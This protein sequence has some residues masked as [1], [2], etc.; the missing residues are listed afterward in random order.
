[1]QGHIPAKFSKWMIAVVSL[2][3]L[4]AAANAE[5]TVIQTS[6]LGRVESKRIAVGS[7]IFVKVVSDWKEGRCR[8]RVGDTIEGRVV[9]VEHRTPAGCW[10]R[11]VTR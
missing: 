8:L 7:S 10:P 2:L 6:L 4:A 1:M 5:D 3:L 11:W 9:A